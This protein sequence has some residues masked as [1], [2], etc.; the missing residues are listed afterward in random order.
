MAR[1]AHSSVRLMLLACPCVLLVLSTPVRAN[2]VYLSQSRSI[3]ADGKLMPNNHAPIVQSSSRSAS[4]FGDFSS[5]VD[6]NPLYQPADVPDEVLGVTAHSEMNSQLLGNQIIAN[7]SLTVEGGAS[8]DANFQPFGTVGASAMSE[9]RI[10]FRTNEPLRYDLKLDA[11][12]NVQPQEPVLGDSR[13]R[14][15]PGVFQDQSDSPFEIG[16]TWDG[17]LPVG[18]YTL[19]APQEIAS[20]VSPEPDNLFLYSTMKL[21]LSPAAIPL[22][23]ALLCG[24]PTLFGLALFVR[25]AKRRVRPIA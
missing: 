15:V 13:G 11:T 20:D 6:A 17:S 14:R 18:V 9:F 23:S 1:K 5:A 7:G 21:S 16:F 10:T 4:G 3:S 2:I 25:Y 24:A 8:S 19:E 22:P 12:V